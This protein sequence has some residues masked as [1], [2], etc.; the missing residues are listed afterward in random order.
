MLPRAVKRPAPATFKKKP[1]IKSPVAEDNS[2][3]TIKNDHHHRT[4]PPGKE[5]KV[6]KGFVQR[7][8]D[9]SGRLELEDNDPHT[10]A[11]QNSGASVGREEHW[12]RKGREEEEEEEGGEDRIDGEDMLEVMVEGADEL[13][14]EE[15]I[16]DAQDEH[17]EE[18]DG[19]EEEHHDVVKERRKR[20]EF[21]V[22]VGGL[23]RDATEGDLRKVFGRVGEI[24]EVRL[25]KNPLTKKNKGFAFLRFATAEQARHAVSEL[26][27]TVVN[28]KPCG[29]AP[30]QD[31]D[32]LFVGNICKE[33]TKETLKEKLTYYGVE[34]FEELTL[35]E[36][37]KNEG[38]NRG[39]AF[40]DFSSRADALE[41]CKRL[42]M[43][44]VVFGTDRTARVAFADTFIEPDDEIMS[45]VRIVFIDGLPSNWDEDRVKEHLK[46]FGSIEKVELARNM[47]AAKRT[48]FGFVT[49]DTHDAAVACVDGINNAE[50]RYG[51]KKVKVR[52]RLSRPRQRGKSARHARG[53]YPIG[54]GGLRGVKDSWGSSLSRMDPS[55]FTGHSGRSIQSRSAY[56]GG[57]KQ[58]LDPRGRPT[59]DVVPNRVGNRRQFP[60]PERSFSRSYRVSAYGKNSLQKDYMQ[61]DESF[62]RPP[63]FPRG[64]MERK[65]YRD[66][67]PSHESAYSESSTR[68]VSRG[69]ARR[70]SPLYD[71]DDS[72]GR[73][74][75]R[76]SS[77]RDNHSRDYSSF[78][79]SKRPYS[80]IEEARPHY[81]EAPIRQSRTRIDYGGGSSR[82][83]YSESSYGSDSTRLMR[84]SRSGYDGVGSSSGG[85]SH[86]LYDTGPSRMGYRREEISREDAEGLYPSYGRDY[87]SEDYL[88]S[89]SDLGKGSY[90]SVY[91]SRRINDGYSGRL[92]SNTR[93]TGE[94]LING[95][96]Q[97]LAYGTSAYVTQEDILTWTLTVREAVF[98][99]AQLQLPNSM[100]RDE[101]KERAERTI[102]EMG[103]QDSMNTR[104]GGW[105]SKGLSGGQKRRVSICIE[106]LTRPKL[107]FLDEPTSGLDS[108]A[109]YYVMSRII[110]LSQQYGMTV[111]ASIHQPSSE[112]FGLFHNLC[113]L[114]L[115][116][117]IYFGPSFATN[118]F[119]ALSGFPCPTLQ[120]PADHYLRT[121]N[122]DFDE[123]I[124]Q[125]V[126]GKTNTEE[127][128]NVLV[129]CYKS[130]DTCKKI[131]RQVAEIRQQ[132]RGAMEKK[133][134]Q[135]S[136]FTQCL[137]L[138]ERS[139]AR[140]SLLMFVASFLTIMA[141]G[142]FPSF[143]EDMKVF[144]RERLN[145]HYGAAAFVIG[146]TLSSMPYLFIISLIP[147]AITYYLVGLQ[148]GNEKFMYFT[149]ILFACMLLVESLMMIVASMVPNFLMG[150]ITGAGIQGLMMLS[151]GFF[152]LPN[153]LP[154]LFWRYPLYYIAFHKY[155]YQGL[156]KNEFEG[157]T[158][159]T[160]QL[161]GSPTIDGDQI[162]RDTW[163]VEMG[164]SKWIDLAI[165]FGMVVLYRLFF[166][167]I[168]KIIEKVKPRIKD[169]MFVSLRKIKCIKLN[170]YSTSLY[171]AK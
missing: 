168:I 49:F 68:N 61:Q 78:S 79:G 36:D 27:H 136:F 145:G 40:L 64:R 28:G 69:V 162:L 153:D 157:L 37:T 63:D 134:S 43:R 160:N 142:G 91:S 30:S 105:G 104:I 45:Q 113:L 20:K 122:T 57:F 52:A 159:P 88:P 151:G 139:F 141:I 85:H 11:E 112:V 76:S 149:L 125:G 123:D 164:Y 169:L 144:G 71:E 86:G 23:D 35:V 170:P 127:V 101:K 73:Y 51:D 132:D 62:S 34:N 124:E 46:K 130:S 100:S 171:E 90:S 42:Q 54:H 109:S 3:N 89:R 5:E 72:Y 96:K 70:M 48:D 161:E 77:Y 1:P 19:F 117:T 107:L 31:S 12:K 120:N 7:A 143:V 163:Q 67:Y 156:Y 14:E 41:A 154:E 146:N 56:D 18:L 10:D 140:G 39:F 59:V 17:G 84:G 60:S 147:G 93:Q 165:L 38:M 81:A 98:Y 16:G 166:F 131:Q 24:T 29:V 65:S 15:E 114:S 110:K 167:S 22:F 106:I 148:K 97:Q 47:P 158:F 121:I 126:G 92:G 80:A 135:A 108:A 25:L 55:R 128:I 74:I 119:F 118:Q 9:K 103:L 75:E 53:G 33:W 13:Q 150:L 8:V 66:V 95:R 82:L 4:S 83:A 102:R 133:G 111:I 115:G 26:K 21:E 94:V 138:T 137:L 6:R 152:R 129:K 58:S 2:H 32:T 155:A 50:L 87:A 116:R 99:S 44:D